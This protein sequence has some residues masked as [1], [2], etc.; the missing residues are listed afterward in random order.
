MDATLEI[1]S[2]MRRLLDYTALMARGGVV[3][4]SVTS[5]VSDTT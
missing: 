1:S 2:V 4:D 5:P 3:G